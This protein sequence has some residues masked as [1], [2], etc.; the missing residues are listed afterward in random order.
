MKLYQKPG[1]KNCMSKIECWKYFDHID[2]IVL[3]LSSQCQRGFHYHEQKHN[4]SA[5]QLKMF[6]MFLSTVTATLLK[7]MFNID[8]LKS[9]T[10]IKLQTWENRKVRPGDIQEN[11]RTVSMGNEA[12]ATGVPPYVNTSDP[13]TWYH[14]NKLLRKVS[15]TKIFPSAYR[16]KMI[17]SIRENKSPFSLLFDNY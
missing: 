14:H 9:W 3:P 16:C 12:K 1:G 11:T 5:K 8:N 17:S 6:K 2:H 15:H 7:K 4:W 13:F 10:F